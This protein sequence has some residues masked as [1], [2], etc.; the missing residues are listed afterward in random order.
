MWSPDD[1]D[2][3][4]SLIKPEDDSDSSISPD[5]ISEP[6]PQPNSPP[7]SQL[8]LKHLDPPPILMRRQTLF[9]E[10]SDDETPIKIEDTNDTESL[11]SLSSAPSSQSSQSSDHVQDLADLPHEI[12]ERAA[13][14]PPH[15]L[16]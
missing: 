10:D 7:S 3:D 2:A 8:A 9:S 6:P 4:L 15:C 11:F 12:V 14:L 13:S 16:A 1:M 5:E